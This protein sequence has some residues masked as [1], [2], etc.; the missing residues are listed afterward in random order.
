[1]LIFFSNWNWTQ[2]LWSLKGW[3]HESNSF[4][5]QDIWDNYLRN[6]TIQLIGFLQDEGIHW[7]RG[8]KFSVLTSRVLYI[9]GNIAHIINPLPLNLCS[10]AAVVVVFIQACVR[11]GRDFVAD[12]EAAWDC[13]LPFVR[14]YGDALSVGFQCVPFLPEN[15]VSFTGILGLLLCML[16]SII[17]SL[18]KFCSILSQFI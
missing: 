4:S 6:F 15:R 2:T 12:F 7:L 8:S 18:N 3:C 13:Y 5:N 1:M 14:R 17:L 11:E 9:C 10:I 16:V